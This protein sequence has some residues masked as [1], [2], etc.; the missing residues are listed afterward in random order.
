[1]QEKSDSSGGKEDKLLSG[2]YLIS[3]IKHTIQSGP[4]TYDTLIDLVTDSL[5]TPLPARG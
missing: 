2:K 5:G 4:N 3:K 1:M